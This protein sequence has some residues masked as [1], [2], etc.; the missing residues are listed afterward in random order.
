MFIVPP[1]WR[2]FRIESERSI[3][4]DWSDGT[5]LNFNY[6]FGK[7]WFKRMETLGYKKGGP[8]KG[9]YIN[10]EETDFIKIANGF[11]HDERKI[12]IVMFNKRNLKFPI[13]FKNKKF[14][15]YEIHKK[16]E[17]N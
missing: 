5:L 15:A 3:Y 17:I 9:N 4:C 13:V 11:I 16:S 8:R 10:L 12:F 2:G 7:E 6:A 14:T 1:D